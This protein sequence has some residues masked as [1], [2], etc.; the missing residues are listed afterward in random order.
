M[1]LA[2]S[3]A[4]ASSPASMTPS[5]YY[6]TGVTE[7]KLSLVSLHGKIYHEV[8]V[9]GDKLIPVVRITENQGQ[10]IIGVVNNTSKISI[11]GNN[12][13]NERYFIAGVVYTGEQLIAS[14]NTVRIYP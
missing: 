8:V 10:R 7:D 9:T 4:D 14:V 2:D 11:P 13:R 1:P 5:I 12:E 6:I 3:V